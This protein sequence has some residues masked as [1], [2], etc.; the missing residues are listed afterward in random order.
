MFREISEM[1][2]QINEILDI[3]KLL[4]MRYGENFI[5]ILI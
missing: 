4:M 5:K 3:F 1:I 2:N